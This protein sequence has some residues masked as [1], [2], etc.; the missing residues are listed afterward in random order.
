M[1]KFSK[2]IIALTMAMFL[3]A[4]AFVSPVSAAAEDKFFGTAGEKTAFQN[5]VGLGSAD[6]K[7]VAGKVINILMGFLGMIAVVIILI[8]GFKWMTAAGSEDKVGEAKKMIAAGVIG[9]VI[10]FS[11]WGLTVFVIQ[12]MLTATTVAPAAVAP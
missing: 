10:I 5:E 7:T 1:K 11:A 4:P 8:G 3:L 9:L 6:P 12:Q 2:S